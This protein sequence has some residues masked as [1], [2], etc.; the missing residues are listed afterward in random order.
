MEGGTW[1]KGG[2][3]QDVF[4]G[5]GWCFAH[6]LSYEVGALMAV[7]RNRRRQRG[8]EEWDN[9]KEGMG[10]QSRWWWIWEGVNKRKLHFY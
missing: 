5:V 10:A 9:P 4:A 3:C 2:G 7:F 6:V 1:N 8:L